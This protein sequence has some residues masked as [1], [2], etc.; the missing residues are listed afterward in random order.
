MDWLE[1]FG[2]RAAPFA[3]NL[4]DGDLWL[5]KSRQGLVDELVEAIKERQSGIM[6]GECGEGKTSLLRAVR[7]RLPSDGFRLTYC[8]NATLGRRDFYRQLCVAMNIEAKATAAALFYAVSMRVKSLADE[9][10]HPVLLLDEAHLLNPAT[11]EHLHI[12]M[13]YEWDSKPLLTVILVGLPELWGMLTLRKHRALWSRLHCRVDLG[14]ASPADTNEYVRYRLERVGGH[15]NLFESNALALL[16][17][18]SR[19]RLRDIDRLATAC[20]RHAAHNGLNR[21]DRHT[22]DHVAETHQSSRR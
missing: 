18:A 3:K 5:P 11:L 7:H 12:L 14:E 2:F 13:N 1:H 22:L 21:I 20:L 6:V 16:H 9:H 4:E 8:H 19:G 15:Q 10:L 17:E